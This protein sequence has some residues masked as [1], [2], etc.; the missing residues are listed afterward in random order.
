MSRKLQDTMIA[1]NADSNEVKIGPWPDAHNWSEGYR[2]TGGACYS[3]VRASSP[4]V[5]ALYL[6]ALAI[7][8]IIRDGVDPK[9]VHE[10]LLPIAEY[11]DA[12]ADDVPGVWD[13]RK[14]E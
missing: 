9:S 11:R 5:K 10:A 1:W 4:H 14:H 7:E 12:L 6:H 13:Y 8:M 3:H 2:M